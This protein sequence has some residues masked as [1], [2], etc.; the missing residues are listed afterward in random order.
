MGGGEN[1]RRSYIRGGQ[2]VVLEPRA[3]MV[4]LRSVC[5]QLPGELDPSPGSIALGMEKADH[6]DS[7]NLFFALLH[8]VQ[9]ITQTEDGAGRFRTQGGPRTKGKLLANTHVMKTLVASR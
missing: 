7:Q 9:R 2:V 6:T 3:T 1:G 4:V 8:Q 5:D